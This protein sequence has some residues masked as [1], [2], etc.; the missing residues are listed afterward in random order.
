MSESVLT[1]VSSESTP[2]NI[3]SELL[4]RDSEPDTPPS[5]EQSVD[6]D[7]I[8]LPPEI[9]QRASDS[10]NGDPPPQDAYCFRYLAIVDG[11]TYLT[12]RQALRRAE[13]LHNAFKEDDVQCHDI[14]HLRKKLIIV[15]HDYADTK[16]RATIHFIE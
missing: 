13:H 8:N 3:P 15:F 5:S 4:H 7:L 12:K 6:S 10:D 11:K 9:F 1:Q 14:K 2:E 16:H